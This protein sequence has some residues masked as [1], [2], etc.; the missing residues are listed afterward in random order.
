[1]MLYSRKI[2]QEFNLADWPQPA[3]T[4]ILADFNLADD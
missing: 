1:M 2:W 4:K 3:S